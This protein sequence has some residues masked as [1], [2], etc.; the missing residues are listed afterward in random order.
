MKKLVV[1]CALLLASVSAYADERIV[2]EDDMGGFVHEYHAQAANWKLEGTKLAIK[3]ACASACNI[4]LMKQY[5]LDVCAYRNATLE[6][7]IPYF[8]KAKAN[9]KWE[10]VVSEEWALTNER[11]WRKNWL[12]HFN[13]KLNNI[14]LSATKR[15]LI[16]SP[17]RDGDTGKMFVVKADSVLPRC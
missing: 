13:T 1:A 4:Y 16:P 5:H 12:G 8:Q 15:G 3:G 10:M 17:N 6:F 2:V 9:G 14:L 11:D 7:H